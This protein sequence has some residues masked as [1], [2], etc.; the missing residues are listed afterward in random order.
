MIIR[1][2]ILADTNVLMSPLT[3]NLLI[4][5]EERCLT[6]ICVS[7][8]ILAEYNIHKTKIK[9]SPLKEKT[10]QYILE[11]KIISDYTLGVTKDL[12]LKIKDKGDLHLLHFA[13]QNQIQCII[14]YDTEAFYKSQL[15]TLN[16]QANHPDQYISDFISRHTIDLNPFWEQSGVLNREKLNV[17]KQAKL[18]QVAKLL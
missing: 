11:K 16:I 6:E 14:T 9:P 10:E 1:Q 5:L 7:P 8:T 3:F 2:R 15:K 18:N 13:I 4:F 17:L 12:H